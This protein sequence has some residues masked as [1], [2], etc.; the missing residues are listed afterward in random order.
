MR[1]SPALE[2]PRV[3]GRFW[4]VTLLAI[5][6]WRRQSKS[7]RTLRWP[8]ASANWPGSITSTASTTKPSRSTSGCWGFCAVDKFDG[9]AALHRPSDFS[10]WTP[11]ACHHR[12]GSQQRQALNHC[13]R[14]ETMIEGILVDRRQAF[15]GNRMFAGGGKFRIT[16]VQQTAAQQA[17]VNTKS[18]SSQAALDGEL[19]RAGRTENQFIRGIL[20]QRSCPGG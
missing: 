18:I 10:N 2:E 16:V 8:G 19:P 4:L 14:N 9:E 17:R 1:S 3:L 12:I 13:L 6:H 11:I 20:D 7:T 15:D 5:N